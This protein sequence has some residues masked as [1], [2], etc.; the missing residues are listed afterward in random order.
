MLDPSP[1]NELGKGIL[2]PA[3]ESELL[4]AGFIYAERIF[5]PDGKFHIRIAKTPIN[6]IAANILKP[7]KPQINSTLV[8]GSAQVL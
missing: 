7:T 4:A 5:H 6:L 2:D 8:C 1:Y 3:V